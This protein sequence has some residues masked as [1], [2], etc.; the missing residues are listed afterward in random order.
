MKFALRDDDLNYF[1]SPTMIENNIDDIWDICP[2][3]MSVIPFVIGNWEE[4]IK[5]L[6]DSTPGN[7]SKE[8]IQRIL[9][10]GAIYDIAENHELV[11]YIKCKMSEG[12]VY[13]TLHGIH[14]RNSDSFLPEFKNN[15]SIGAEFFTSRDLSGSLIRAK[16][17]IEEIFNQKV[18]VFTPPQNLYN[19]IGYKAIERCDLNICAYL[20]SARKDIDDTIRIIGLKNYL[21]LIYHKL[22]NKR[23]PRI[24]Y[25]KYMSCGRSKIIEHWALQPGTSIDALYADFNKVYTSGGNFV[26]STHSCGFK[27]RMNGSNYL[28]GEV[29]REF[30]MYASK[31]SNIKFV[32]LNEMFA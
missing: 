31:K 19:Y 16:S 8:I 6:E 17:H 1:F 26:L 18:E 15:Y 10:D 27:K 24:P 25:G 13:L 32:A 28:M 2:I 4:N 7:V 29:L 11:D 3:S 21:K 22:S 30:L 14:H 12:R 20:P 9:A 23:N 5:L